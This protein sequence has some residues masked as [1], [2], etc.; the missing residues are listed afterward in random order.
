[1]LINEPLLKSEISISMVNTLTARDLDFFF[2][3]EIGQFELK[4]GTTLYVDLI[5]DCPYKRKTNSYHVSCIFSG[6]DQS[7]E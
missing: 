6:H 4:L 1:M 7:C 5:F 3:Q 2:P